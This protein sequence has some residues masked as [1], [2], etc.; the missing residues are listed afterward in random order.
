[1]I[2]FILK[3]K[4]NYIKI[5]RHAMR[6]I[7][8]Q[9][10]KKFQTQVAR[11]KQTIKKLLD[12]DAPLSERILTLFCEQGITIIPIILQEFLEETRLFLGLINQNMKEP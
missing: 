6:N 1:M 4:G 8:S 5:E 12:K 7:L 3:N 2:L 11:I 9:N 10:Q